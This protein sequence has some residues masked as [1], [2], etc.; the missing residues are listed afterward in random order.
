MEL[1]NEIWLEVLMCFDYTTLK[2]CERINKTFKA[3]IQSACL[4]NK[5]F[6]SRTVLH[7]G[8]PIV[9]VDVELHPAFS[10]VSFECAT[11]IEH[12]YFLNYNDDSEPVVLT[13]SCA[14][15]EHACQPPVNLMRLQVH[16]WRAVEVKNEKG[17]TVLQVMK[18]LCRLF[19]KVDKQGYTKRDA[20]GDHTGWTGWDSTRL[21]SKGRLLLGAYFFDS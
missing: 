15:M 13:E 12:A 14:A 5:L 6:R 17:V 18:A 7:A 10:A 8:S 3:M 2:V 20:M 21:D 1:P 19:A 4:D 16:N 9:L 11:R